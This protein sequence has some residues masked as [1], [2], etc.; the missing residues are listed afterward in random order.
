MR[1][2]AML[3]GL[4]VLFPVVLLHAT[5]FDGSARA[6]LR[7][8]YP[9]RAAPVTALLTL[10]VLLFWLLVYAW[11]F[12]GVLRP[13]RTGD[14]DLVQAIAQVRADVARGRPRPQFYLG[15]AAALASMLVLLVL[16]YG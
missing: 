8:L 13:H 4:S 1:V 3:A 11:V 9:G 5:N 7:E 10:G 14:R 15:V 2:Y 16:R 12:L 6:F